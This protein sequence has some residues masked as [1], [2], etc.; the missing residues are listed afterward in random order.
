M[1]TLILV[2]LLLVL[3]ILI[4]AK[5]E[6]Q[7]GDIIA[8]PRKKICGCGPA[9]YSHYAI[10]VGNE[11]IPGKEPDQDIFHRIRPTGG[12]DISC[13]FGSLSGE[14]DHNKANYLDQTEGYTIGDHT[15]MTDR[16]KEMTDQEKCRNYHLTKNNC[17]HLVTYVRYGR[18]HSEQRGTVV[19]PA[20]SL[21][22]RLTR[23]HDNAVFIPSPDD[24][25]EDVCKYRCKLDAGRKSGSNLI[26]LSVSLLLLPHV[27]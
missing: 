19:G 24:S 16:I 23:P 15:T 5:D 9:L 21:C 25:E 1:K 2:A 12:Q 3:V 10:Y 4:N 11:N 13:T 8:F 7:F 20:I 18:P 22:P 14:T 26:G 6:Y 27:T 17:E